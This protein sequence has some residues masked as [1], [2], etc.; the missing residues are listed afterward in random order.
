[1]SNPTNRQIVLRDRPSGPP[2]PDN[3]ALVETT[4]RQPGPGE[5]LRRAIYVSVDPYMRGRMR[6]ER[7][8]ATPVEIGQPMEA[9]AVSEVVASN[10]PH[11]WPGDIV[12]G[13]DGWQEYAV[14]SGERLRKIDPTI[15][16]ISYSLGVLGM[17]GMTAYVALLDV[18]RPQLGDGVVVSAA[19]GAVGSLAGQIAKLKGCRVVGVAGGQA[20]CDYVVNELG[21]DACVDHRRAD[22]EQA[23]AAACPEGIDVYFDNVAGEVLAAVVKNLDVG[24]RIALVG[25]ISEY[26]AEARPPGPNLWPLL[27]KRASITG[28]LVGDHRHRQAAFMEDVSRWLK[29][30]KVKYREHVVEGLGNTPT[31]FTWLF[32]GKNFGKLLVK[33]REEPEHLRSAG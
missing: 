29:E 7:S 31:A 12:V 4:V 33:V 21:F 10:D 25:L 14:G 24:A 23:L 16:P 18:G 30:G 11:F 8:Y 32:E 17:P 28:F 27:V 9:D 15:A 6:A 19:S 1:M 13:R 22:L 26:N 3:F 5:V 2:S 20:K